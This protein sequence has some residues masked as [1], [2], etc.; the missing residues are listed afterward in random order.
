M[1]A[2]EGFYQNVYDEVYGAVENALIKLQEQYGIE[3]GDCEPL[4][5][6]RYDREVEDLVETCRMILER[7]MV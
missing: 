3:D 4:L 1:K 6:M 5:A 7:Q 2:I